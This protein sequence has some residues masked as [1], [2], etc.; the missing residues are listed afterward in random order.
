VA[1]LLLVLAVVV[2][3]AATPWWPGAGAGCAAAAGLVLALWVDQVLAFGISL[4]LLAVAGYVATRWD[5][6]LGL[7]LTPV[8]VGVM[9]LAHA[10]T[11][12]SRRPADPGTSRDVLNVMTFSPALPVLAFGLALLVTSWLTLTE[13][14][15]HVSAREARLEERTAVAAERARL[16]RELHDVVAHHVSLVAVRAETAP[17]TTTELSPSARREFAE[18]ADASRRALDELRTLLGVLR[19]SDGDGAE[20]QPQPT[21]DDIPRLVEDARSAGTQ[22]ILRL[23]AG[24]RPVPAAVAVAAY[25]IVQEALTN[26]RRHAPGAPVTVGVSVEDGRLVTSVVDEGDAA[27]RTRAGTPTGHGIAGMRERVAALGGTLTAAG[28]ER[29][30][31]AVVAG[32]PLDPPG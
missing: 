14:L 1:V 8:L 6:R 25:R 9:A 11:W 23:A 16:A 18:I 28:T 5:R 27:S 21:L 7:C 2:G 26:A 29:G 20:L 30:G 4:P 22:V 13:R 17:Y 19:R 10:G 32:L 31:F 3:V 15:S 12:A 24:A